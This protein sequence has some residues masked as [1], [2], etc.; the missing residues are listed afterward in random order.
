MTRVGAARFQAEVLE[1]VDRS[2]WVA[3]TPEAEGTFR[4]LR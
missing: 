2:K 3:I 1:G 4:A